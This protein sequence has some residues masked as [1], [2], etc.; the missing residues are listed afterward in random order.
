MIRD[1]KESGIKFTLSL[2]TGMEWRGSAWIRVEHMV[3][4]RSGDSELKVRSET[5]YQSNMKFVR[6]ACMLFPLL[7]H[8]STGYLDLI[9]IRFPLKDNL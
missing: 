6:L 4:V 1:E 5:T 7:P 9:L 2:N 8:H 3:R